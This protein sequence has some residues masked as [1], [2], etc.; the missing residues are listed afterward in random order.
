MLMI[1]P[2]HVYCL[3][4]DMTYPIKDKLELLLSFDK[5]LTQDGWHIMGVGDTPDYRTLLANFEKVI[6]VYKSLKPS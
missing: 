5:K 3:E 4:D 1:R 6:R 2:S